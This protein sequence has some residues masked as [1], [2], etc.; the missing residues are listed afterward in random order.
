VQALVELLQLD[1]SA[2]TQQLP[3]D[4]AVTLPNATLQAVAS[5]T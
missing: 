5:L 4:D 3:E 1:I 2:S